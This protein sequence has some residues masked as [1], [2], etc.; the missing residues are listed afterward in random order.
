MKDKL[1]DAMYNFRVLVLFVSLVTFFN[2][3]YIGAHFS[4]FD[5]Y[6]NFGSFGQPILM[7]AILVS[8]FV[9]LLFVYKRALYLGASL[10]FVAALIPVLMFLMPAVAE[11]SSSSQVSGDHIAVNFFIPWQWFLSLALLCYLPFYVHYHRLRSL[12]IA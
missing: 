12:Q 3:N 1:N 8:T 10:L 2:L 6:Q 4:V 5:A 7:A 11:L 9:G